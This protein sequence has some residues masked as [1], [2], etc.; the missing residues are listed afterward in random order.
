MK[1]Y[2]VFNFKFDI[3]G[4]VGETFMALCFEPHFS[5]TKNMNAIIDN[6]GLILFFTCKVK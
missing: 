4:K 6:I 1:Y 2:H 3:L 5:I